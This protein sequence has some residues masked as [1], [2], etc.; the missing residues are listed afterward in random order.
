LVQDAGIPTFIDRKPK[1]AHNKVVVIH[2]T[3]VVTGSFNFSTNAGCCN[4]ENLLAVRR[5]ELAVA[6]AENFARRRA[7][8]V[9]YVKAPSRRLPP[10]G[11]ALPDAGERL[12]V[13]AHHALHIRWCD[14]HRM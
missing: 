11:S 1:I 8:S 3:T 6:Y 9:E 7:V 2:Q 10:P 5:P 13:P 4:A 14:P 12:M